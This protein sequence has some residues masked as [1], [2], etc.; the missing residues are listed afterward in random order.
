MVCIVIADLIPGDTPVS[1]HRQHVPVPVG[2]DDI[3]RLLGRAGGGGGGILDVEA[4]VADLW[5]SSD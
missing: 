5:T 3:S 4:F 2:M 1:T